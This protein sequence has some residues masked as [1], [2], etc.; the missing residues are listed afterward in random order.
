MIVIRKGVFETNSSSVH[1][2]CIQREPFK[3]ILPEKID[4]HLGEFGWE[5]KTYN[6]M[7]SKAS[8]LYTMIVYG[9]EANE[10]DILL[11]KMKDLLKWQHIECEFHGLENRRYTSDYDKKEYY[12]V[13]CAWDGNEEEGYVDHASECPEFIENVLKNSDTLIRYLCGFDSMIITGN[14][15]ED[16]SY[17]DEKFYSVEHDETVDLYWKWN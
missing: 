17:I 11:A 1:A 5:W 2:I 4:F 3:G 13:W 16:T 14:D 8:Y 6:T 12:N 10:V 15:N 7:M 9:R